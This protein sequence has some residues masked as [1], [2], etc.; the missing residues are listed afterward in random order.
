MILNISSIIMITLLN[1]LDTWSGAIQAIMVIVL[2]GVT[3]WY[4]YSTKKMAKLMNKEYSLHSMP[5][6]AVKR[7]INRTYGKVI[8]CNADNIKAS[9]DNKILQLDFSYDNVGHVPIKHYTEKVQINGVDI[10]PEKVETI[11]FPA[12]QG[13]VLYSKFYEADK[14][15]GEGNGLKGSIEVI[16]WAVGIP[17]NKISFKRE[18]SLQ[19]GVHTF[20]DKEDMQ[21]IT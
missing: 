9:Q 5:F 7:D 10:T 8:D 13:C 17:E 3:I 20:I 21:K 1:F 16:Y 2:V 11:I 4:A 19:P 15:I 12:Q 6:L 18:F 14:E